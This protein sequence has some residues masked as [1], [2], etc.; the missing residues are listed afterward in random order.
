M[1]CQIGR[2]HSSCEIEGGLESCEGKLAH[3]A[4]QAP[5]RSSLAYGNAHRPRQLFE[6]VFHGL[7]A[8]ISGPNCC[9]TSCWR[10]RRRTS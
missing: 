1:F 3:L 10:R 5:A 2:A 6:Q 8:K 7:Y 4:M 9:A